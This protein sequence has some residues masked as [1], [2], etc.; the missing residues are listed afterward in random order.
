MRFC[1]IIEALYRNESMPL[2]IADQ[3][4]RWG[5]EVDLLEPDTTITCLSDLPLLDY[6][7]YV[8]KTVSEGPGLSLL[9]AA[10]AV[11][12]PT[13]NSSRSIRLVRDKAVATAFAQS[14]GLPLPL[15]Y[16]VAHPRLLEQIPERDYPL[17]VKPTN[18]SSC[19]GIYRVDS[20]ADLA[21]LEIAEAHDSFFLAQHYLENRGFDIKLY[22]TGAQVYGV[23][24]R[25][26]LHPEVE[27]NKRLIPISQELRK[28]ALRVGKIFGLGI[29]GLDVL[30]TR[31]GPAVVDIND[32]PSFGQVPHA[33]SLVSAYVLQLASRAE[34][35]RMV[36][37]RRMQRRCKEIIDSAMHRLDR[38]RASKHMEGHILS[39]PGGMIQNELSTTMAPEETG[40]F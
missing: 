31:Q 9:E 5:H 12:I 3:L 34:L 6:D 13:I 18:G 37:T 16:F 32:F 22:V 17:V 40:F 35:Q 7:A 25:S 38:T 26:P 21:T 33:V 27:V 10:E 4:L 1:F 28:L 2:A 39:S 36:P 11:G 23:A 24:K 19:R 29:Y 30:E 14:Q 15:T 8:L 20:P